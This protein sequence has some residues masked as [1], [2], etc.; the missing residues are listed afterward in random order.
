MTANEAFELIKRTGPRVV[1]VSGKTST[2]KSTFAARLSDELGFDT[3]TLDEVVHEA[4]IGTFGLEDEGMVFV[5]VYK[6]RTQADWIRAFIAAARNQ[7]NSSLE[8]GR[9]VVVDGAVANPET[10]KELLEGFPSAVIVYFHPDQLPPYER[11]LTS[12]FMLSSPTDV[13]GLP[14]AFW[15]LIS[16]SELEQFYKDRKL[17]EGLE[18]AI[19]RYALD[20]QASSAER[21]AVMQHNF[22]NLR[23]VHIR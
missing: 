14:A 9:P 15:K 22:D 10:L 6:N 13:A 11:N 3:I 21:L 16:S 2:G 1:H 8:A 4:V 12:R 17:T 18:Q 5:E 19:H 23:V 7:I 20:S